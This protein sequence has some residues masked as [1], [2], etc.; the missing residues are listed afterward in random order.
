MF[1]L[2]CCGWENFIYISGQHLARRLSCTAITVRQQREAKSNPGIAPGP[3]AL[4]AAA[5]LKGVLHGE[6][7]CERAVLNV[8]H[9]DTHW[10]HSC[11]WRK[12]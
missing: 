12:D 4:T 8:N 3:C 7:P 11:V 2:L 1:S 9:C 6:T 5:P 10:Q